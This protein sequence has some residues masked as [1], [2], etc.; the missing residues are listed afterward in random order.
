[1]L[2][3]NSRTPLSRF[4]ADYGLLGVLLLLCVVCSVSTLGERRPVGEQAAR[5]VAGKIEPSAGQHGRIVIFSGD[6]AYAAAL[7]R[8]LAPEQAGHVTRLT[9][10]TLQMRA[11]LDDLVARQVPISV[12]ATTEAGR[13]I[14]RDV[15][16]G[17]PTL[18]DTRVVWAER[19]RWPAFLTRDNLLNVAKKNVVIGVIAVG[20]TMVII[21]G[22][23]DL[24]VGSLAALSAV[25]AAWLIAGHGGRDA[26]LGVM[27]VASLAAV[28]LCA[29]A[30]SF[31]GAM[32]TWFKVPP[33]VV[34]LAM[35]W[36]ASG[37]A[38]IIC[39][40]E[41]I[42]DV[43][44][45]YDRLGMGA[46]LLGIPNALV[47]MLV[48]FVLGHLLMSRTALGR[49]VYAI[50]GN[51]QA[52]RLS[53]IR[54]NRV[55]LIVYTISGALAGL[56]GV[57]LASQF[58]SGSANWGRMYELYAIAAVV[59]GGTSLAGGAGKVFGTLIG[60]FT[61]AVVQNAMNLLEISSYAQ[62]VVLGMIV[63][64]VVLLDTV[65]RQGLRGLLTPE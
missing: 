49:H 48:V 4:L 58:K 46:D 16:Q 38:Y 45:A 53:G 34:T 1:M 11:A 36:V 47:L 23:I 43:P 30:G 37:I 44:K 62:Y 24:S 7:E 50:G 64:A 35:M 52:A 57:M 27:L 15:Q 60:V 19:Y 5:I 59:V 55:L 31:S 61:M 41:S 56:G 21:T 33:F 17:S 65:K 8:F 22:G 51:R 39:R 54:V 63:L 6:D 9:G 10:S 40:G 3:S 2:T 29:A 42:G 14:V 28:G 20:M 25:V 13:L 18:A 32:V 12:I 26:G